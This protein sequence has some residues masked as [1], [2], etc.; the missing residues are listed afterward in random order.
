M[1][2]VAVVDASAPGTKMYVDAD[3]DTTLGELRAL[4]CSLPLP[5]AQTALSTQGRRL[6]LCHAGALLPQDDDDVTLHALGLLDVP[7]VV[8]LT[9]PAAPAAPHEPPAAAAAEKE[10]EERAEAEETV[11]EAEERR[12]AREDSPA[13]SAEAVCRI[14]FGAPFENGAGRLISPCR[15]TG[16]MRYVHIACLNEWRSSSANPRSLYACDQCGY[17]YNM[18]RTVYAAWLEDKRLHRAAAV[19]ILALGSLACALVLGPLGASEHLYRMLGCS[20]RDLRYT[21]RLGRMLSSIWCWQLDWLLLG[22]VGPGL[23][24][25]AVALQEAYHTNR[26]MRHEYAWVVG[27]VALFAQTGARVSLRLLMAG[28]L[29]YSVK[30]AL[31]SVEAKAK[32]ELT[33]WGTMI[34]NAT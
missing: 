17:A 3:S 7:V 2:G 5:S 8:I 4:C 28:G 18:Q 10:A 14:C 22:L 15:C 31:A 25:L 11:G 29:C 1:A 24:G 21:N 13:A 12:P 34:L 23:V 33:K 9:Q 6:V 32:I 26:H 20:P 27:L 16:S 30:V 19:L